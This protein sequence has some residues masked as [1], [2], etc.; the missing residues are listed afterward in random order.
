MPKHNAM[1]RTKLSACD[2]HRDL[3]ISDTALVAGILCASLLMGHAV[4]AQAEKP[5]P[6]A[7][8]QPGQVPPGQ[9]PQSDAGP[10]DQPLGHKLSETKGVIKPPQGVDPGIETT[11]PE[12]NAGTMPVIPPPGSAGGGQTVQPK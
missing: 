7:Q 4:A 2:T 9:V 1:Q 11:A 6:E 8:T 10:P 12:P 3:R 5:V